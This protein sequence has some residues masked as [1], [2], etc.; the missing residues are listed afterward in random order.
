VD[1]LIHTNVMEIYL[2]PTHDA[3]SRNVSLYSSHFLSLLESLLLHYI[4]YIC[5]CIYVCLCMFIYIYIYM[6]LN[7][8]LFV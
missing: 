3:Y 8:V 4:V 2:N 1:F 5:M 6:I 7:C